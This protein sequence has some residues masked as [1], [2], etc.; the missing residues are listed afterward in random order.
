MGEQIKQKKFDTFHSYVF[1]L[2]MEWLF[3]Q[4]IETDFYGVSNSI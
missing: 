3:H 4:P 1:V 2:A